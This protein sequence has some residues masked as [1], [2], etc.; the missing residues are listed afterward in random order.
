MVGRRHKTDALAYFDDGDD[1]VQGDEEIHV[2]AD[3]NRVFKD[4]RNLHHGKRR[5]VADLPEIDARLNNW[6]PLADFNVEDVRAL[7]STVSSFDVEPD[8]EVDPELEEYGNN[9]VGKRKRY[10]SSDDPM[11]L[12]RLEQDFFLDELLRRDGLGD[13]CHRPKCAFCTAIYGQPGSRIF[14]CKHCGDYLQ[15]ETCVVS[16]HVRQPLHVLQE[17]NGKFWI[18]ASLHA[19]R[20]GVNGVVGLGLVYQL[21]HHGF[22]CDN[23]GSRKKM[24]VVD[25]KGIF[26]LDIHLCNC[27]RGRRR[28]VLSHLLANGWYPATT[29]DPET[30]ATFELLELFRYLNVVGNVNVHD[31]I[32]T[33]ERLTDPTQVGSTPDRYK[34]FMRMSRQYA[35]LKRVKRAGRGHEDNGLATTRPGGL[36]VACWACPADGRNLPKG[37]RDVGEKDRYL[38]KLILAV[39]A[40]FRLKNRLRA[41]QHQDPALGK[42]L[43]YFVQSEAY[44]EHLRMYVAKKDVTSCVAF[45]ALLQKETRLTTGLRVS[46]VGGCVCARHGLVRPQ[47]LG[48]LQKGERYANMD[49]IL[50]STLEGVKIKS[51]TISYDIACQWKVRLPVRS[52]AIREKGSVSTN[53]DEFEMQFALPVWHA[54]AHELKCR[55]ANSLSYAVGVGKTDGEGIERTWSVLNPIGWATKEMGE[56]ARHDT[57]EDKVDHINFEKNVGQG[58]SLSRKLIVAIGECKTQE[59]EFDELDGSINK[60]MRQAW[61]KRL[62][63]WTADPSNPNPYLVDGGKDDLTERQVLE[64]LKAAELEDARAARAPLVEGKMTASAFVKAGLQLEESQR[65]I[66]AALKNTVLATADRSSQIQEQCLAWLKKHRTFERLQLTYMPGVAEIKAADEED[67]DRDALPA[68]AEHVKLYLPS[69]LEREECRSA[70]LQ[71]AVDAESKLRHAQA[72]DALVSLRNA[73]NSKAHVT[74]YRNSNVVGQKASTR[75]GTLIARIEERITRIAVKYRD[76]RGALFRLK[77]EEW[78]KVQRLQE[79]TDSDLTTNFG[80]ESDAKAI[81]KLREAEGSRGSRNEPSKAHMTARVS[82]IWMVGSGAGVADLHDSVRVDWTKAKARRA[83]WREEKKLVREEMKFV[84]R[85]LL[86]VQKEW[87]ARVGKRQVD[88]PELRAGLQAYALRQ[89]AIHQRIAAA[90]YSGWSESVATSVQNVMAQDGPLFRSLLDGSTAETL[91]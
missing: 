30:C 73:L 19:G 75:S 1:R 8:L 83:R 5:R 6:T 32:G 24:V 36:A 46:G 29:I 77:G 33:L 16:Q 4:L 50:L 22:S 21:G 3:G 49:F 74:Q 14:R 27:E 23:P 52:R 40:N 71:S 10:Q 62:D 38:Y 41:N 61:Q 7:A 81:K 91:V 79:L 64:Q 13:Y 78:L 84:L 20:H 39:D 34:A 86:L 72:M 43:G 15:C 65:R 11:S 53:L 58:K 28:N 55:S 26:T 48:D 54:S 12:W 85:S 57:I 17:W 68:Q 67:R 82:W 70:C 89:V 42:G 88:D 87:E 60:E 56:G 2:S 18:E 9:V 80:V 47:G 63:D 44:K 25:V 37:W 66:K 69:Q 76:A 35:Y 59:E 31:F 45:A 51:V 90:F